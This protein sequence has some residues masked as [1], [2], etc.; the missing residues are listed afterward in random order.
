[1]P[2]TPQVLLPAP[3]KHLATGAPYHESKTTTKNFLFDALGMQFSV[4]VG[5]HH[6][7]RTTGQQ[8]L[9]EITDVNHDFSLMP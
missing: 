1:M 9:P 3:V 7:R 2:R 6:Y 5:R 4:L 8:P